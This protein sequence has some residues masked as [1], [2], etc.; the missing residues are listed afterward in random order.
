MKCVFI[1]KRNWPKPVKILIFGDENEIR[2]VSTDV[3]AFFPVLWI[4]PFVPKQEYRYC[5]KNWLSRSHVF[6]IFYLPELYRYG[7]KFLKVSSVHRN[8]VC[9]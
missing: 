6:I 3:N 1:R 8:C 4:W 7:N 5:S 9:I 2:S